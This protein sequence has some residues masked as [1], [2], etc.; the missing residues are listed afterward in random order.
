[1]LECHIGEIEGYTNCCQIKR[2][3]GVVESTWVLELGRQTDLELVPGSAS[4]PAV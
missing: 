1:M 4:F 3:N 2:Q